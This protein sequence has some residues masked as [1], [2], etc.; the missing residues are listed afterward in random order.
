MSEVTI[1]EVRR[2]AELANLQLTAAEE[3]PMQRI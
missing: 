3:L 1:E 2:V